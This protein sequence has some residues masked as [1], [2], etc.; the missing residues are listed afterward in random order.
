MFDLVIRNATLPDGRSGQDIAVS[1]D[2]IIAVEPGIDAEAGRVI[3]AGG[4]LVS[5]PFVDPH[6]HMDATLSLGLPRMN[7]SGTLLEGIA[8]WGEL[9]PTLTVDALVER[10]VRY[11]DLAVS[12]GLLAI[13]SHVDVSDPALVTVEAML[14]VRR[15]VAPYLDLQLVAF[16]QDGYYRGP[17]IVEALERALDMGVDIVGGIPHFER[18][19]GEGTT[20]VEA[21]CRIAADRGLRVDMHC[22]ETDDPLSRHVETLA[23]QTIR[24]GLQGR[25]AGSHLTSMHSMD[26][27]YV[28]KL[29]PLIA[30]AQMAAIPNP[31]INMM[32]QGR[33]DTYPKR[34]GLTRIPQMME[35]GITV[36]L[37][38]DCVMDP[39]YSM[40]TGDL[41][42]VA[43][44]AVHATQM[45]S[46]A[47]KR[48][49]FDAVT[50]NSARIMGLEGYGLDVGCKADM[51][52]LQ[53]RDPGEA[54]RLRPNRQ[55]VIR[56]G[57]VVAET[58]PET[59]RLALDG[60]PEVVNPADYA[61]RHGI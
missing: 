7:V 10:A 40:G 41:L 20:S 1:A 51:V 60:R 28:S 43:H 47:D 53:A 30:E 32:L 5:P 13:R 37:G 24:F 52:L 58:A 31:L 49:L 19:M 48:A 29:L 39:W 12:K 45:G 4:L 61:P 42:D 55:A 35:M 56:R 18:T 50:V 2:T 59:S 44:M 23:A 25:V 38:Q 14:E 16:P 36:G 6:F 34:R 46:M 57:K 54:I 11:C 3:D 22:D 9:R 27:Y 15:R 8:L 17:G 26:N 33:H 21:L